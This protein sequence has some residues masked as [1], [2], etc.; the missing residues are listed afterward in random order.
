MAFDFPDYKDYIM[1]MI[2]RILVETIRI[3]FTIIMYTLIVLTV[4]EALSW[5]GIGI[6]GKITELVN[7]DS[8]KSHVGFVG[9]LTPISSWTNIGLYFF[10]IALA[11]LVIMPFIFYE[12][13]QSSILKVPIERLKLRLATGSR[14]GT[15]DTVAQIVL[16]VCLGLSYME[17]LP[18]LFHGG[19]RWLVLWA[20]GI[21]FAMYNISYTSTAE[22]YGM[23]PLIGESK[24]TSI[25][26]EEER[27]EIKKLIA[28][29]AVEE[30]IEVETLIVNMADEDLIKMDI[31]TIYAHTKDQ[32]N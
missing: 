31:K 15:V 2:Y 12:I 7:T 19:L 23:I 25:I 6:F 22:R 16:F 26:A 11:S 5:T 8:L 27:T 3:L 28:N 20:F 18:E 29:L 24:A 21:G 9:G 4:I 14:L 10:A 17:L 30:R 32:G 13:I 1:R